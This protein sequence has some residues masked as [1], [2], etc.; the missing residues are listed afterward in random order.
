MVDLFRFILLRPPR[1]SEPGEVIATA[2]ESALQRKL[3]NE[4]SGPAP[5][6]QM[7]QTANDFLHSDRFVADVKTLANGEAY[8][9]L[10]SALT[11]KLPAS[12]DKLTPV[13][14]SAFNLAAPDLVNDSDFM[15]DRK[16]LADSLI[17]AKL[18]DPL[19]GAPLHLLARNLR[20]IALVERAAAGDARLDEPGAIRAALNASIVLPGGLLPLPASAPPARAEGET[21]GADDREKRREEMRMQYRDLSAAQ[22][23]L[24]DLRP[25]HFAD[26]ESAPSTPST[27]PSE[28]VPDINES[29]LREL[30]DL[31]ASV[32]ARASVSGEQ[33]NSALA[34][35]T[36]V[37]TGVTN[38]MLKH[39]AVAQVSQSVRTALRT[40]GIDLTALPVPVAVDRINAKL[41]EL[42]PFIAEENF[43][44][45]NVVMVGGQFLPSNAVPDLNAAQRRQNHA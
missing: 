39:E 2:G 9:R 31:R 38:L 33:A 25:E 27:A 34:T 28:P 36:R 26:L 11:A 44:V 32:N 20:L 19:E 43:N 22:A 15:A 29:L 21:A 42:Y 1:P 12:L 37:V 3:E 13:I 35:S 7:V 40:A 24:R 8:E 23:F 18:G 45:S 5:G 30:R 10:F 6:P 4:R 16:R 14:K 41:T 17:A